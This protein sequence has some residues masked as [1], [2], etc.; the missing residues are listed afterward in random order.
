MKPLSILLVLLLMLPG[1]LVTTIRTTDKITN[2]ECNLHTR[3]GSN[4][5]IYVCDEEKV[6]R[7]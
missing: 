7:P 3:V 6:K 4:D 2:P 5:P 1:C